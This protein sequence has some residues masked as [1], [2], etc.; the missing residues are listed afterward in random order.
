MP[1]IPSLWREFA[2]ITF[3]RP[4]PSALISATYPPGER[5]SVAN[6][7]VSSILVPV[8]FIG[9]LGDIPLSFVIAALCH[10]SHPALVHTAVAALGFLS[11]GWAIAAR[12]AVRSLP[13]VI[14]EDALWIG[15]GVRLVGVIPKAAID[16]VVAIRGSRHEWM[17]EYGVGRGDITVASGFDPPNLAVE[18]KNPATA[19]IR[20]G[21]RGKYKA[22][23][24]WVLLYVD[25]PAS[26]L[27]I[28]PHLRDS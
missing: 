15:G 11:L 9:L 3:R 1:K 4:R 27:A 13:H 24:R 18:I 7:P 6:G 28:A 16:R 21:S 12:S 8:V 20:I 2:A 14:S 22:P 17:S 19:T 25:R 26:L 5:H 10:P 23:R